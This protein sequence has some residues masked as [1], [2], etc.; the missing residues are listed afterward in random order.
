MKRLMFGTLCLV[1]L[2]SGSLLAVDEKKGDPAKDPYAEHFSFP[3]K[4][5]LKDQQ[6]E[7]LA[8]L[9]KQYEPLLLAY[10]NRVALARSVKKDVSVADGQN[11][12][13]TI[14]IIT[15]QKNAL[16]DDAQ[17]QALGIKVF[18]PS[19]AEEKALSDGK[20]WDVGQL[21]KV[22]IIQSRSY[23][24]EEQVVFFMVLTRRAW[25]VEERQKDF[26]NWSSSS[27]KVQAIFYDKNEVKGVTLDSS[28]WYRGITRAEAKLSDNEADAGLLRFRIKI[29]LDVSWD[30]VKNATSVNL[31]YPEPK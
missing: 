27:G 7:K 3:P 19:Y 20:T 13:R 11:H 26:G 12:L 29:D 9:R 30:F 1:V 14:R 10:D 4:I 22:F 6:K 21:E 31:V 2:L 24:P 16:L 8:E 17:K 5:T 25:T 18:I 28:E 23:D 15:R